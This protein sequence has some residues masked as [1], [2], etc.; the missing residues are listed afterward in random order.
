MESLTY[1]IYLT[2]PA[3]VGSGILDLHA[4]LMKG[5]PFEPGTIAGLWRAGR[6]VNFLWQKND[7]DRLGQIL[8]I[9]ERADD[10]LTMRVKFNGGGRAEQHRSDLLAERA[11]KLTL[12]FSDTV[13]QGSGARIVRLYAL[14]LYSRDLPADAD[15][16]L[17]PE[18]APTALPPW[19]GE[20]REKMRGRDWDWD[21][22]TKE[23]EKHD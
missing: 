12:S 4:R 7:G 8:D 19:I 6:G 14:R 13:A 22:P 17:P 20:M 1:Q 3:D 15:R 9:R 11:S 5:E 2:T 16:R 10:Q 18:P 21:L 23:G